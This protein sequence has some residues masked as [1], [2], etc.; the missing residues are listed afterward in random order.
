MET[1]DFYV[2][3]TLLNEVHTAAFGEPLSPLPH[4]KAQTLSWLIE[5]VTGEMLSY[6][7]LGNYAQAALRDDPSGVNPNPS[8]LSLL[9]KFATGTQ[10]QPDTRP[11]CRT[12]AQA[13]WYRYRSGRLE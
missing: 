9:V 6:K 4:G 11:G 1:K 10:A 7:T 12:N 8:T 2:F 3:R 13:A 5:E